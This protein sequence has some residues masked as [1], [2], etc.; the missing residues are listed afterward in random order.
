MSNKELKERKEMVE[1][2]AEKFG[3]MDDADKSYIVG[4]MAGKA[5]ERQKWEKKGVAV[6]V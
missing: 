3:E 5:E 6:T 1:S 4:Y 2:I